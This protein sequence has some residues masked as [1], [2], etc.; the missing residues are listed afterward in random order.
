[1]LVIVIL[2]ML[3][4]GMVVFVSGSLYV[5]TVIAVASATVTVST[6]HFRPASLDFR[7]SI[8]ELET[9]IL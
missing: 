5:V 4:R 7:M 2:I 9:V 6:V 3:F 1:M 8:C